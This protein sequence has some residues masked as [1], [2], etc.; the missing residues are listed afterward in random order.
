MLIGFRFGLIFEFFFT[1]KAG[2]IS[3]IVPLNVSNLLFSRVLLS[4]SSADFVNPVLPENVSNFEL[5]DLPNVSKRWP[6]SGGELARSLVMSRLSRRPIVSS[7]SPKML[8]VLNLLT[9]RLD[10]LEFDREWPSRLRLK[11]LSLGLDFGFVDGA[12]DETDWMSGLGLGL[13]FGSF[14][15]TTASVGIFGKSFSSCWTLLNWNRKLQNYDLTA[16]KRRNKYR[17]LLISCIISKNCALL[18]RLRR[19][20]ISFWE[21]TSHHQS[22][23]RMNVISVFTHPLNAL[24][25][26]ASDMTF[27]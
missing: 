17:H 5:S 19:C 8:S 9:L 14:S 1:G 12:D 15:G 25:E 7:R 6:R 26:Q 13:S 21:Q 2:F 11:I 22:S 4:S 20:S 23:A 3:S 24:L 27:A 10:E 16:W 18:L